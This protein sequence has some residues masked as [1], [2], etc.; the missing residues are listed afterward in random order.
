MICLVSY[1]VCLLGECFGMKTFNCGIILWVIVGTVSLFGGTCGCTA[2]SA[3]APRSPLVK[4]PEDPL[5]P[6]GRPSALPRAPARRISRS[7]AKAPVPSTI[8]KQKGRAIAA[9]ARRYIG[10]RRITVRRRRFSND[11][12]GFVKAVFFRHGIHLHGGTKHIYRYVQ[13]HGI[14]HRNRPHPGDLVFFRE[15][16]DSNR[17]GRIN[18]GLTHVAIVEKVDREGTVSVIHRVSRGIVR[19]HMNLK[20]PRKRTNRRGST[21]NDWLRAGRHKRLTGQL[22]ASYGTFLESTE[23]KGVYFASESSASTTAK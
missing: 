11:C 15:T 19:Y 17:D 8:S 18:D 6:E 2:P 13:Q 14:L 22:F 16:Y 9:T 12:S 4:V 20:Y 1:L 23:R 7:G 3:I 10:R 21:I 5:V